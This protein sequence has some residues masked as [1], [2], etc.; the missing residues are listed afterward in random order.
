MNTKKK[1]NEENTMPA[2]RGLGKGIDSLIPTD[3]KLKNEDKSES[4]SVSMLRISDIEPNK[5]Q[6]RKMFNE[7]RLNE[8]A[9]SIKQHGIVEPL[10][11]VK[12]MITM[13]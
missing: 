6:P 7:D 5:T 1:I 13:R 11:V 4:K 3:S 12:R 2:K 9:E 8:L 10:I